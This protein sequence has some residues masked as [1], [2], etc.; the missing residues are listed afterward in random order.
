[1]A[2]FYIDTGGT[3]SAGRNGSVGQEW[4][5]LAYAC[6]RVT[7]SGDIIHVNAGTYTETAQSFLSIGVSV[8][9]A[10]VTSIIRSTA[11]TGEDN[12]ILNLISDPINDGD[13]EIRYLYFDGVSRTC[14]KA[15]E[16]Q[17][18]NG[19]KIHHCTIINFAWQGVGWRATDTY[20]ED[21]PAVYLTGSEFYN[22]IVTNC[23][24]DSGWGRG[25]LFCGGHVGM[26]IHD[27]TMVET[28][29]AAGTQGWPIKFWYWGG[30]MWGCKIYD[31]YLESSHDATWPFAIE[32]QHQSG[33]EIYGN[34]IIGEIDLNH[35]VKDTYDYG[36]YIHDNILGP[37]SAGSTVGA[38][39]LEFDI[40]ESIVEF[41][42]IKNTTAGI[43]F[44][45][46][47][48]DFNGVYIRY[49]LFENMYPISYY[50]EAI[51][52]I[53]E[54]P[55]SMVM[56]DVYIQNNVFYGNSAQ[57][58]TDAIVM[59][60]G[61]G[62]YE[63]NNMHIE[64]NIFVNWDDNCINL[65]CG[66][67]LDYLYIENNLVYNCGNSNA[68]NITGG[69]PTNYTYQ[70]CVLADNPDFVSST[71]FHLSAT[72]PAIETGKDVGLE[73]DYEGNAVGNPPSIGIYDTLTLSDARV[74]TMYKV[75]T[76]TLTLTDSRSIGV[77]KVTADTLTVTD[78]PVMG[79][80][81]GLADTV[82]LSD[83][84]NN[85]VVYDRTIVDV[86]TIADGSLM[87]VLTKEGEI[88]VGT[89]QFKRWTGSSWALIDTIVEY[90]T[91]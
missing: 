44:T 65:N 46:R 23:A 40:E 7:T 13:Q 68:P 14:G 54:P 17:N 51:R 50:T 79:V 85:E 53:V 35:C 21:A 57:T 74:V 4:L 20:E 78:A 60:T 39:T 55:N 15:I 6:T 32:G 26:L 90:K 3:N 72:S 33:M 18:R 59:V 86:I 56:N 2:T 10:G 25:A 75:L 31:N 11:I 61:D 69:A 34:T 9:G 28:G 5:T 66:S 42:H 24:A 19:V 67:D 73:E 8:E 82:T 41:N 48:G 22:N 70:N 76:D 49:N 1:M 36:V 45:P 27:N 87:C 58:L 84:N 47:S 83:N 80:N 16:I 29:R 77:Y 91:I 38:I 30:W 89:S 43:L 52:V 81:K 37:T 12:P 63:A 62:T 64:N 88:V 71:D